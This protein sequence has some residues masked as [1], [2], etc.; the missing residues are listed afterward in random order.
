MANGLT[1][2]EIQLMNDSFSVQVETPEGRAKFAASGGD[3]VRDRLREDSFLEQIV[4]MV[5]VVKADCQQALDHDTLVKIIEVEPKSRALTL[6]FRSGPTVNFI[7]GKRVAAAFFTISSEMIQKTEQELAAYNMPVTKIIEENSVK[8]MGEIQ[9]R[10]FLIN[11]EAAVQGLQKEANGGTITTLN[12]TALQ[13]GSPPVEF[14]VVKGELARVASVDN[15]TVLP[16]QRPDFVRLMNLIDGNR[17]Q[18]NMVLITTVDANNTLTWTLADNGD[19][20]QSETAVDGYKYNTF[21]GKRFIKTIKTDILRPGNVYAF[22]DSSFFAK[23]YLFNN[24]KFYVDKQAN[25]ITFQA[26]RDVAMSIVN[27]AAVRKLELYSGDA[28][29]NDADSIFS[30]ISP[31]EEKD[32]GAVNN[33]V[34][35]GLRYPQINPAYLSFK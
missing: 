18:S 33:R 8:D 9:D 3:W 4:P 20:L 25:W 29:T 19:R 1:P 32:L 28:T 10:E 27:V 34:A 13:G 24:T 14:S 15:G 30:S 7:R 31:K 12:A 26:W 2:Q 6:D 21:L 23:A 11:C 17:L 5:P 35:E 16:I 22:T